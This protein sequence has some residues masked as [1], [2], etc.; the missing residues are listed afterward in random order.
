MKLVVDLYQLSPVVVPV[1]SAF[2]DEF[3]GSRIRYRLGA[4]FFEKTL[5]RIR[6]WF[7]FIQVGWLWGYLVPITCAV[8]M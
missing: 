8:Q 7:E 6:A 4:S 3:G 1:L 5:S 2:E